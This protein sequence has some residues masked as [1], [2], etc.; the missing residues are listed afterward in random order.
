MKK[1][2]TA[3][4]LCFVLFVG[5]CSSATS[6]EKAAE[7]INAAFVEALNAK[8]KDGIKALLCEYTLEKDGIDE[9]IEDMFAFFDKS[10]FPIKNE[11]ITEQG[12][13]SE[14]SSWTDGEKTMCIDARITIQSNMNKCYTILCTSWVLCSDPK[15]KGVVQIKVIDK[16][17]L[18]YNNT[19]EYVKA[20]NDK[21]RLCFVG[22]Y[23][24]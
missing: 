14:E 5:G 6:G 20:I 4:F 3:I 11:N 1:C 17:D 24:E 21:S 8:D 16:T 15:Q 9:Q 18:V 10:I 12:L 22:D 19:D 13:G 7:E 2:L 23:I